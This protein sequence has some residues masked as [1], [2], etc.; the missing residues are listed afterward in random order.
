MTMPK[1]EILFKDFHVLNP[2][3]LTKVTKGRGH[4]HLCLDVSAK[5]W[6]QVT[7][8]VNSKKLPGGCVV[9]M[10]GAICVCVT[11]FRAPMR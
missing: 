5:E 10:C 7:Q 9:F 3:F 1:R 2:L 6:N 8:L 4:P 11:S